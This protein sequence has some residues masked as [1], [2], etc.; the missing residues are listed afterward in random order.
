MTIL[1]KETQNAVSPRHGRGNRWANGCLT[2]KPSHMIFF[3]VARTKIV[4]SDQK[5]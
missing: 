3:I 1:K 4:K 5:Y 2:K